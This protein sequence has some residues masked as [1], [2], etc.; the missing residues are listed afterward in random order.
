MGILRL[1]LVLPFLLAP[2]LALATVTPVI[3][4][5]PGTSVDVGEEV[6]FS[7]A[8]STYDGNA[9]L[10]QKARYEW[11]FGD[12]YYLR[13]DP[14]DTSI[15]RQGI[16]ATHYYMAPGSYTVTM[17]IKLWAAW[18]E[19][20]TPADEVSSSS[21]SVTIAT[22][23]LTFTVETGKLFA[24]GILVTINE[25]VSDGIYRY[26]NGTISSYN[27]TTGELVVNITNT[28]GYSGFTYSDWTIRG[29]TLPS[30]TVT[31]TVTMTVLGTAPM[32]GF[33]IQRAPYESRISQYLYVQIPAAYRA[34][35]TRLRLSLIAEDG[36]NTT[37]LSKTN[38]SS[39]ESYL[40]D[41]SA[42]GSDNY[43]VQA[44]LLDSGNNT[45][46]GGIWRDKF[47]KPYANLPQVGIDSN[48]SF[49]VGGSL[50]FPISVF[51]A[52]LTEYSKFTTQANVN[53][54][55]TMGYSVEYPLNTVSLGKYIDQADTYNILFRGPGRGDYE[56]VYRSARWKYNHKPTRMLDYLAIGK[57][58]ESMFAWTW[59]DEPNLGGRT[60]M[61]YPQTLAAWAHLTHSIDANH[62]VFNG[63]YG[64]DWS[65]AY[66]T[67]LRDFD[68]LNSAQFFGGKKWMQQVFGFDIYPIQLRLHT[69]MNM[70]SM[71]PIAAYF[72]A[73]ER[74]KTNNKNLVPI[75]PAINP[76]QRNTDQADPL[77]IP[78]ADQV[79]NLCWL[80][81]IHGAKGITWFPYF[82]QDTIQWTAMK[83]FADEMAVLDTV[84]LGGNSTRT[85]TDDS[86][87]ALNRVDTM[88]RDSGNHVWIFTGR[89]TEPDPMTGALY[90][91]VEGDNITTT[92]TVSGLS[93]SHTASVYGEGRTVALTDGVFSDLF[94]KNAV[95]IYDIIV[96]ALHTFPGAPTDVTGAAGDTQVVVS[97]TAPASDGNST[98]TGYTVT[99]SPGS[100]T[101][102]GAASPLTV[103]G[104]TNGTTYTFTVTATNAIGTGP[105][106]TASSG[107]TPVSAEPPAPVHS[108]PGAPTMGN[109][110]LE[111]TEAT[112]VFSAPLDDGNST[113]TLY[114]A[115]SDPDSY[116]GTAA[117][118]PV[119]VSGLRR[120]ITYTFTVTATN[121][122]GTGAASAAS[123]EVTPTTS[124]SDPPVMT[125]AVATHR[126]AYVYFSDPG[127]TGDSPITGYTVTSSPGGVTATG[128]SSPIWISG[129]AKLED[130]TFTVTATNSQGVS[131]PSDPTNEITV[132]ELTNA[133]TGGSLGGGAMR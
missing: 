103:T 30:E 77:Q 7:G 129:L 42:L 17:Q 20:G 97:F 122:Y 100:F 3:Q 126:G 88:I 62:P 94:E 11:D 29:E 16:C 24:P 23:S 41:Q 6:Y 110:T 61:V 130:F 37:L 76:G 12:G 28:H 50:F 46:S 13:Y 98:I 89:L 49:K 123:N 51:M 124:V 63:L 102:T 91:G 66:G 33:E 128:A 47:T 133:Q 106:S 25:N 27:S 73:M 19:D 56:V 71:G 14:S 52:S 101:A 45:I 15:T 67:A 38:L 84:V 75:M 74:M 40:F 58:D 34:G 55:E 44:L 120:G 26:M 96:D 87:A 31:T 60:L 72:D 105:A 86:N 9:T 32:S 109:A 121:A 59:Q 70:A 93:G 85:V 1:I 64:S 113:I 4:V 80:N 65:V 83:Q 48:N 111:D 43:T 69:S 119:I 54:T 107:V 114:T 95:H 8:S 108:A 118:S 22:G 81:V 35:T 127:N 36:G 10:L 112:I 99:S 104:L 68:Y 21:S 92:F 5:L 79:Y 116:T 53:M 39:E 90:T 82:I 117:A 78:T 2:S 115:T 18:D 131:A 132:L 57:D 125:Y